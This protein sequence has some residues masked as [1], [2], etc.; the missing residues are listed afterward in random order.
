MSNGGSTRHDART[1]QHLI[2]RL[3]GTAALIEIGIATV[4]TGA[5]LTLAEGTDIMFLALSHIELETSRKEVFTDILASSSEGL[6]I[7]SSPRTLQ[8]SNAGPG[9][10]RKVQSAGGF[11]LSLLENS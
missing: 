10:S 4:V 8:C 5:G 9:V 7:E 2:F 11:L 3:V 6:S 1:R